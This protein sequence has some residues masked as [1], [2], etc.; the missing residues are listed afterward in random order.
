M[1]ALV[2]ECGGKT[3]QPSNLSIKIGR[4]QQMPLYAEILNQAAL[5]E[6][7]V[8]QS[9]EGNMVLMIKVGATG[10]MGCLRLKR[11]KCVKLV[12]VN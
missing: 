8:D 9:V 7:F 1:Q 2:V 5:F 11:L 12:G 3:E 10:M 6:S 4:V